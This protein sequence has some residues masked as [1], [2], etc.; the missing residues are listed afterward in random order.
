MRICRYLL[1][2]LPVAGLVLL[3]GAL[4]NPFS[5]SDESPHLPDELARHLDSPA[6]ANAIAAVHRAMAEL[7]NPARPWL[8]TG[9]KIRSRIPELLFR[10]QG[11]FLR[12]SPLA[13]WWRQ[14]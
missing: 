14:I 7:S 1:L 13:S 10:G 3:T 5:A 8:Q 12:D 6:E 9:V 11:S 4:R 2:L